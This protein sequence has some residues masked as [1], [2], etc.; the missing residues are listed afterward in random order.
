MRRWQTWFF[1]RP[2]QILF[3]IVVLLVGWYLVGPGQG[4][5]RWWWPFE[6]E[7]LTGTW[8]HDYGITA[9]EAKALG[10]PVSVDMPDEVYAFMG[11]FP[12]PTRTHPTVQY[13]PTPY[14][15]P[16]GQSSGR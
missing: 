1:G 9:D 10:L 11:L 2:V 14:R 7:R 3:W 13:I 15:T 16:E 8:T 6:R 5:P 12:Q 4:R